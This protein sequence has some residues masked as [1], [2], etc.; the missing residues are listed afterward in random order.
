M[1]RDRAEDKQD[2]GNAVSAGQSHKRSKQTDELPRI[3][4]IRT[5]GATK[6]LALETIDYTDEDNKP[7]KWDMASRTKK[8]AGVPDAVIIIPL[9]RNMGQPSSTT[10]T[11]LVEQYRIPV[12]GKTVEF[13]AG[14]ID[15][16]ETAEEAA[17]RE[18]EEETGYVGHLTRSIGSRELCM[19]PGMVNETV[20]VVVVH[21]DLDEPR[22]HHPIPNPDDGELLIVK[23]VPIREGLTDMMEN[24][25][26]MPIALLYCFALGFELGALSFGEESRVNKPQTPE[27]LSSVVQIP[28]AASR[29]QSSNT[30]VKKT[31]SP[32]E[33]KP[34]AKRSSLRLQ[35]QEMAGSF[36]DGQ[37]DSGLL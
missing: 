24:G 25:T 37:K 30:S 28:S 27:E 21:V 5:V 16:G 17:V 9:L 35:A 29:L 31:A 33:S 4:A 8:E 18:L 1:N 32:S 34:S 22:N 12:R 15:E 19:T 23:R 36:N 11:I 3:D 20:K 13:P 26:N 7:R 10:E 6:W 2:A 14:L